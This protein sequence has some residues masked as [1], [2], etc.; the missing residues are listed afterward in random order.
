M[1][2]A[3][4]NAKANSRCCSSERR[5]DTFAAGPLLRV[6]STSVG[7]AGPRVTTGGEASESRLLGSFNSTAVFTYLVKRRAAC[8]AAE[9]P[10]P[11]IPRISRHVE[12]AGTSGRC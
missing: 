8:R 9:H 12:P 5:P 2:L 6:H 10:A 1:R 3:Y 7:G 4:P 11:S